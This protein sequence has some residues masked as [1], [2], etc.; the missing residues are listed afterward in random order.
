MEEFDKWLFEV[1]K[2]LETKIR[3]AHDIFPY[4]NLTDAKLSY[5]DGISALEYSKI[6]DL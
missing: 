3:D 1:C 4:I 6:I 2:L 5:I